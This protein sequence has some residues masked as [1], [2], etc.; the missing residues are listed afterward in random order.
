MLAVCSDIIC[1]LKRSQLLLSFVFLSLSEE[2]KRDMEL[3]EAAPPD[4]GGGGSSRALIPNARDADDVDADASSDDSSD[5]SET[6]CWSGVDAWCVV[7]V[8]AVCACARGG[9]KGQS[10]Q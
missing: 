1:W 7:P 2:R 9:G 5:V 10:W 6:V 4:E 8:A 3:L